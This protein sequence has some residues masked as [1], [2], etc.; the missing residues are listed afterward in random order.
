MKISITQQF[1]SMF[2]SYI[3]IHEQLDS[4]IKGAKPQKNLNKLTNEVKN[5]RSAV[6]DESDQFRMCCLLGS[7]QAYQIVYS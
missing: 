5:S 6:D 4:S 3:I 2:K 1:K 7:R